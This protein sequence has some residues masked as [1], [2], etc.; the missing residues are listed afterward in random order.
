MI[1]RINYNTI[2]HES[3]N[4]LADAV[5]TN[6]PEGDRIPRQVTNMAP[7][8]TQGEYTNSR[9]ALKNIKHFNAEVGQSA[10]AGARNVSEKGTS[11]W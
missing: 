5:A 8:S 10:T 3:I 9:Y 7:S 6:P 2:S 11:S 1:S 4:E